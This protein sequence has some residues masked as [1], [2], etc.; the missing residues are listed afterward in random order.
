MAEPDPCSDLQQI[1]VVRRREGGRLDLEPPGR[2]PY[3]GRVAQRV[4]CCQQQELLRRLRQCMNALQVALLDMTCEV[5]R[6]QKLEA[7]GQL[8]CAHAPG[9]FEQSERIATRLRDDPLADLVVEA[10]RDSSRQECAGTLLVK[11]FE[12]QLAEA[13]ELVSAT[14]LADR[15]HD[16]H[17]F[18]QQ[19]ARD[20]SEHLVRSVVQ[21][22]R[23]IH[24]TEQRSLLGDGRQQAEHGQGDE[25]PVGSGAR[26]QA[27]RDTQSVPLG[28]RESA[29]AES[30][31]ARRAG[32]PRRTAT[33]S[34]PRRRRSSR[35]ENQTPAER[36]SAAA[37]SFRCPPRPARP[38]RRSALGAG[39]P[40]ARRAGRIRSSGPGGQGG[41]DQAVGSL[42]GTAEPLK[43]LQ[44]D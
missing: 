24:E 27:Q 19:P 11:P 41:C 30:A 39:S 15:E 8:R 6:G 25:E 10:A 5:F 16:R 29:R 9:Q 32:A 17:R 40:A 26:R 36:R 42:G 33:P 43:F 20:K 28:L 2:T 44:P 34:Q 22:L 21:P 31:S 35:H 3:E 12:P 18:R 13:L 14:R 7:T 38:E 1:G 23:V 4:R 37:P